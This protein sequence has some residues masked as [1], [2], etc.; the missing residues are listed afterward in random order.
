MLTSFF[1]DEG[2]Y[3]NPEPIESNRVTSVSSAMEAQTSSEA[4]AASEIQ[5]PE[6]PAAAALQVR[7]SFVHAAIINTK[8]KPKLNAMFAFPYTGAAGKDSE[9]QSLL[10]R[11]ELLRQTPDFASAAQTPSMATGANILGTL[12]EMSDEDRAAL[13]RVIA[14]E[15]SIPS[16]APTPQGKGVADAPATPATRKKRRAVFTPKPKPSSEKRARSRQFPSADHKEEAETSSGLDSLAAAAGKEAA[17]DEGRLLAEWNWSSSGLQ[18][19]V[20]PF[21]YMCNTLWLT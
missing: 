10:N 1:L 21:H 16:D 17:Q 4:A 8:I 3:L 9:E 15:Y 2:E 14:K 7:P 5:A 18:L 19:I 12:K 11:D 6:T 20:I 13:L